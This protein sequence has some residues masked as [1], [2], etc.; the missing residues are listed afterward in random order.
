VA[1]PPVA[2]RIVLRAADANLDIPREI[3]AQL[4]SYLDLL[5][6]WN[7]RI[8]LTALPVDPATDAAIDRLIIEPLVA[9][10]RVRPDDRLVVDIGSGGGSPA[11]PLK[12][13]VPSLQMVLVESRTRKSAFLRE[14]VRRLGLHDVSVETCRAETLA[15]SL[16][17]LGRVDLV[18]L[19]AV[20]AEPRLWSVVASL[21]RPCGR[22]F[23]FGG[24]PALPTADFDVL[25]SEA[26]NPDAIRLA[27]LELRQGAG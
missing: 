5:A 19:R 20:K 9:A 4:G 16:A 7:R 13:A 12:I 18:T 11:F 22:V 3:A 23:W 25:E 15:A 6:R 26:A 10:R 24:E 8:N 14:A 1:G 27:V 17:L 2:D 21:L